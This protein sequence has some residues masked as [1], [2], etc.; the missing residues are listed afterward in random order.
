[1]WRLIPE[2]PL[3]ILAPAEQPH[4]IGSAGQAETTLAR[5]PSTSTPQSPSFALT[6]SCSSIKAFGLDSR[7]SQPPPSPTAAAAQ[8]CEPLRLTYGSWPDKSPEAPCRPLP[9]QISPSPIVLINASVAPSKR[10]PPVLQSPTLQAQPTTLQLTPSVSRRST[11]PASLQRCTQIAPPVCSSNPLQLPAPP[12]QNPP[13]PRTAGP[14]P[15]SLP[16]GNNSARQPLGTNEPSESTLRLQFFRAT[17][18]SDV[19][20]LRNVDLCCGMGGFAGGLSCASLGELGEGKI[21]TIAAV[22]IDKVH[23]IPRN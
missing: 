13:P 11:D 5:A 18:D 22:D 3:Q 2:P 16:L 7:S 4:G 14:E 6:P 9:P 21:E 12:Q 1:L 15:L 19:R 17:R 10:R 20:I 23:I 8:Y